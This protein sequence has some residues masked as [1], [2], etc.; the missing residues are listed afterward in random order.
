MLPYFAVK[1]VLNFP[2]LVPLRLHPRN[3]GAHSSQSLVACR[4]EVV[5]IV[6]V[7]LYARSSRD[8]WL[9]ISDVFEHIK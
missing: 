1:T 9:R 4:L 6:F 7:R 3:S 8:G 2:T 5:D